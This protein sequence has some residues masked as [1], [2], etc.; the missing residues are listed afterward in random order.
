M[1][2]LHLNATLNLL[3]GFRNIHP[4]ASYNIATLVV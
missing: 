4:V 3:P 1:R 2:Y